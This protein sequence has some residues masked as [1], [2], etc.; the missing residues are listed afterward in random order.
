M[1]AVL[2]AGVVV[3]GT[4]GAAAEGRVPVW[5]G[6]VEDGYAGAADCTDCF[7]AE[8]VV[9]ACA[10][11]EEVVRVELIGLVPPEGAVGRLPVVLDVDGIAE[12]RQAEIEFS[13]ML[14]AVPVLILRAD[15]P[16]LAR[17]RSGEVLTLSTRGD[18]LEIPLTGADEALEIM[19]AGCR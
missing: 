16:L 14:G 8:Y 1:R 4:A 10:R 13:E 18:R 12:E 11:G 6:W 7:E 15:D 19:L 9:L 5:S 2:A 3:L 17:L